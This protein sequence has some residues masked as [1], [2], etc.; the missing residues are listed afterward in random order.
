MHH[1]AVTADRGLLPLLHELEGALRGRLGAE[2]G[3]V[4]YNL[5]AMRFVRSTVELNSAAGAFFEDALA[6]K[7]GEKQ[8]TTAELRRRTVA[9][10]KSKK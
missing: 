3:V 1:A 8:A 10:K 5:A 4:G 6:A 2:H 9:R 7:D